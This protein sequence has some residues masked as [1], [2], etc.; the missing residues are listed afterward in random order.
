MYIRNKNRIML[1][2]ISLERF[3]WTVYYQ[4]INTINIIKFPELITL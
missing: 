2:F 3:L 4:Y 1:I